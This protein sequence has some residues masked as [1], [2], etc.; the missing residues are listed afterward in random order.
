MTPREGSSERRI[1]IIGTY[2][3]CKL[4]QE[5]VHEQLVN[6]L[7]SDWRDTDAEVVLLVRSE[8]AGVVIGKCGFVLNQIREQSGATIRLLRDEVERQRPC[9]IT[10]TLQQVL[11][12]ERHIFDLVRG[13]PTMDDLVRGVPTMDAAPVR[14]V[15]TTAKQK[16]LRTV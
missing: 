6:A 5:R 10:G 15:A 3:Q 14:Q 11:A 13:V 1:V 12:A 7:R 4:A 8:A 9:I 16:R 2:K